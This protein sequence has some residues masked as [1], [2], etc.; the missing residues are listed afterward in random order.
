VSAIPAPTAQPVHQRL[1]IGGPPLRLEARLG[2]VRQP[3]LRIRRRIVLAVLAGWAPL[4]VLSAFD[5]TFHAAAARAFLEDCGAHFRYL[6]A[7]PLLIGA[8]LLCTSWL[9]AIAGRFVQNGVVPAE[10]RARFDAIAESTRRLLNAWPVEAAVVLLAYGVVLSLLELATQQEVPAWMV[11][12][13]APGG[14]ASRSVAGWWHGLVSLP[15]LLVLLLGWLWRLLVWT[16]FLWRVSRLRL[17]VVAVHPDRAGGLGFVGYSVRAWSMVG[18]ALGA[19]AAGRVANQVLQGH[20]LGE[21]L[22]TVLAVLAVSLALFVAPLL[23]L[24]APLLAAWRRGVFEY[25]ALGSEFGHTFEQRWMGPREPMSEEALGLGDFSAA[26]D[27]YQVVERAYALRFVPVDIFSLVM[28]AVATLL[29]FAAVV[30]MTL[31]FDV[32]LKELAGLLF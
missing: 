32:V 22:H 6:L 2:L 12:E 30:L 27:I 29:P 11:A 7:V 19:V 28:L 16:H 9:S 31:P 18:A 23:T 15:L 4:C 24:S 20:A 3:E 1:F 21:Y 14:A 13:A 5:G 25:G 17:R 10:E 26:T 8:E